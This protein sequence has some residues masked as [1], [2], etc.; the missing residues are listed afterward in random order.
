MCYENGTGQLD[1]MFKEP[2]TKRAES[3]NRITRNHKIYL[4]VFYQ[5]DPLTVK[6]IH[7]L[8]PNI[9]LH[10]AERQLNVSRNALSHVGFSERWAFENGGVVYRGEVK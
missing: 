7:E 2:A 4:A 5:H 3:L 1:R 10:E 8:E 6:T 9:A